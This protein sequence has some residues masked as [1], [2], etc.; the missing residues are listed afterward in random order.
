MEPG[1]S[2]CKSQG[3]PPHREGNAVAREGRSASPSGSRGCSRVL[4]KSTSVL[5]GRPSVH[6]RRTNL[7]RTT[8]PAFVEALSAVFRD[9]KSAT[10]WD[11]PT[12]HHSDSLLLTVS[13]PTLSRR[14]ICRGKSRRSGRVERDVGGTRGKGTSSVAVVQIE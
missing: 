2:D 4:P 14:V 1:Q 11:A 7:W 6:P 8:P 12:P 10:K 3:D 13:T 5:R 9:Q